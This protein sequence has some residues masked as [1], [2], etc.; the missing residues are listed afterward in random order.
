MSNV[1]FGVLINELSLDEESKRTTKT[2]APVLFMELY[3]SDWTI[4]S[5]ESPS[6]ELGQI[7][8]RNK[9]YTEVKECFLL[10]N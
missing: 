2:V 5:S 8:F 6:S 3:L 9:K 4:I 1:M 10:E 7:Q